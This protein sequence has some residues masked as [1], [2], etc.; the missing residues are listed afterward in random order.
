MRMDHAK[1]SDVTP[2]EPV[3]VRATRWRGERECRLTEG[4][5]LDHPRQMVQR[6][7]EESG[8][9]G[10]DLHPP[11][12][13]GAP[14]APTR[15]VTEEDIV[16]PPTSHNRRIQPRQ[17]GPGGRGCRT[18]PCPKLFVG[19]GGDADQKTRTVREPCAIP[20]EANVETR[21]PEHPAPADD[22]GARKRH[23]ESR[24][25]FPYNQSS[26]VDQVKRDIGHN[27]L[28]TQGHLVAGVSHHDS[29]LAHGLGNEHRV[30]AAGF[31]LMVEGVIAGPAGSEQKGVVAVRGDARDE[32][33]GLRGAVD[34][35]FRQ[36]SRPIQSFGK[37]C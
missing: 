26:R 21:T 27:K 12:C 35:L 8:V 34:Q 19:A 4:L 28:G 30:V 29:R 33:L 13:C 16:F 3:P 32:H 15:A 10:V 20:E 31:I 24:M 9:V 14:A 11:G 2:E 36:G 23:D 1:E 37:V 17:R 6:V 5:E 18:S 7:V 22:L 25:V